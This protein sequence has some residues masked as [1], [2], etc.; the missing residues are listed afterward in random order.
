[1]TKNKILKDSMGDKKM[2]KDNKIKTGKNSSV[3]QKR[4][5]LRGKKSCA[6]EL[7]LM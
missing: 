1:M 6:V 3:S 5:H 7:K 2:R 4:S